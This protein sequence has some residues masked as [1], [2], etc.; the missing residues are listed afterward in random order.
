MKDGEISKDMKDCIVLVILADAKAFIN[1]KKAKY[2]I[3]LIMEMVTT[4]SSFAV[5]ERD[6]VR[7]CIVW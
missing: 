3:C 6:Y 5:L 7:M 1:T 2:Y 4:V